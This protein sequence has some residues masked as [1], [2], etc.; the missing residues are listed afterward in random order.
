MLLLPQVSMKHNW[1]MT[2]HN[3]EAH[4]QEQ[5]RTVISNFKE[6]NNSAGSSKYSSGDHGSCGSS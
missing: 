6:A 5:L 3:M 4:S 1:V 2:F